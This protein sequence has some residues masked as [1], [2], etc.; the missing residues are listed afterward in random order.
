METFAEVA[1]KAFKN[2]SQN[3]GAQNV[4][5][6]A[7]I[8]FNEGEDNMR[9]ITLRADGRYMIRKMQNGKRIIKYAKTLV[10]AKKI[11][12]HLRR[13]LPMPTKK[14]KQQEKEE[15]KL[16]FK[17]WVDEWLTVY[18]KPFI[19]ERTFRDIKNILKKVCLKF[20]N[21][22][23][24]EIKTI[25]IQKYL[26]N[27]KHGRDKERLTQYFNAVLEKA[28]ALDIINKNPFKAVVREKKG[29]YKNYCYN[30]EEQTKIINALKNSDIEQDIYIYLL[31][32]CRPAEKPNTIDIDLDNNIIKIR[33]T[34]TEK[35]KFR[36]IDISEEFKNYLKPFVKENNFHTHQYT[37]T[38]F[39]NLCKELNI[40][41]PLLYRLRHTFATNHFTLGT[42]AKQVAEWMGHTSVS[43]TLD[44]YTDID[45]Q[46]TKEKIKKLYNNFYF[47]KNNIK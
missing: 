25:D 34:K 21:F 40:E 33:G 4:N 18:K 13:N 24:D 41:K 42:T 27:L 35:S 9:G 45:K 3:T 31:T 20:G 29:I 15:N 10:E 28:T 14:T 7:L 26:N 47:E 39:M 30:F 1:K 37:K 11:Y 12:S 32:G 16:K 8:P 43:I 22:N 46:A 44:T 2:N 38:K 19:K 5:S 23:V 36:E 6:K 17:Q